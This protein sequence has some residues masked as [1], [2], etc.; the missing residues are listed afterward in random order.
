VYYHLVWFSCSLY[1]RI[2]Y[3]DPT[4]LDLCWTPTGLRSEWTPV[5][6][7][8]DGTFPPNIFGGQMV[9]RLHRHHVVC[10]GAPIISKSN[11]WNL[12]P[13][14]R[15]HYPGNLS[16]STIPLLPSP[17]QLSHETF[18]YLLC[19]ITI[20]LTMVISP[21][22]HIT[23][24]RPSNEVGLHR[25]SGTS[26]THFQSKF[27]WTTLDIHS[28]ICCFDLWRF[29]CTTLDDLTERSLSLFLDYG[30]FDCTRMFASMTADD[31]IERRL[32]LWLL[33][34]RL[35]DNYY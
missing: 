22:R 17:I 27:P 33:T 20:V 29:D 16:F 4:P 21:N 5:V 32:L 18:V 31:S 11:Y 26:I 12:R 19:D 15:F 9:R 2:D 23:S 14:W 10:S 24:N 7:Y 30:R 6:R 1:R 3:L 34:I 25:R 13:C 35:S 28:M 8:K